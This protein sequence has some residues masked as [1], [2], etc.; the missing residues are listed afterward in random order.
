MEN[1]LQD[2]P[3]GIG[4][5]GILPG[6]IDRGTR[7]VRVK[8][9][10]RASASRHCELLVERAVSY[11]GGGG[12]AARQC[13]ERA[14]EHLVCTNG[15]IVAVAVDN[16]RRERTGLKSTVED[17]ARMT[18]RRRWRCPGKYELRIARDAVGEDSNKCVANWEAARSVSH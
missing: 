5:I 7:P 3:A 2:G 17:D 6:D 10:Q 16:P 15:R 14:A 13:R 11:R 18:R 12:D 1:G 4:D 9:A 8:E